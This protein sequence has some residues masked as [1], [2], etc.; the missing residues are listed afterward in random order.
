MQKQNITLYIT[1]G[2]AAYKSIFLLRK[3]IKLG[4]DVKVVMTD[5]ATKFIT[6]LTF[7]TL[8]NHPVL[9][10][11]EFNSAKVDHIELAE[12]TDLAII[13]P[14]TAN[15]IGKMANGIADNFALTSLLAIQNEK[16]YVYPAMNNEMLSNEATQRNLSQLKNDHM[17][18]FDTEYGFLAE[19]YSAKGRMLEPDE[20][21]E[22]LF[23]QE[24]RLA[25]KKVL[26]TAGGTREKIDPVRFIGNRSSGKMG[27]ALAEYANKQGAEVT[28]ISANSNLKKIDGIKTINVET[29]EELYNSIDQFFPIC[30]VLI[31]SAAVSDF[32]PKQYENQKIKKV[33]NQTSINLEFEKTKDI[34]KYFGQH[35]NEKQIIIGFAAETND[36]LNNAQRKLLEKNVDMLVLND[37]SDTRIGFNSDDNKVTILFQNQDYIETEVMKKNE[38]AK[39]ILEQLEKLD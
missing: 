33:E 7:S 35:K 10:D 30:D 23:N 36:I 19:G 22:T 34:L 17:H 2:I 26:I 15:F 20:I 31:M 27:Y 32:K 21:I 38:I 1:G 39:I 11:Y 5:S 37:V 16:K 29:S 12:W 6:P 13:A 9:F 25:G 8:S 18:V 4:Y 24:K 14:A 28:L 3:L